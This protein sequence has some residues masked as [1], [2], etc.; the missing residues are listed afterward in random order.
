MPPEGLDASPLAAA[1]VDAG[2]H[3]LRAMF[4][5]IRSPHPEAW[6]AVGVYW[7][8]NLRGYTRLFPKAFVELIQPVSGPLRLAGSS[9]WGQVL[10]WRQQV[11]PAVREELLCRLVGMDVPAPSRVFPLQSQVATCD[12]GFP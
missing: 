9:T 5:H 7:L 1:A 6:R 10:D 2:Q 12:A 3:D 4:Q 8:Y 11:E